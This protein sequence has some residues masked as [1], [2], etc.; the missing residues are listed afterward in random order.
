MITLT[1]DIP[2]ENIEKLLVQ[3]AKLNAKVL[4]TNLSMLDEL[5][6]DDYR[7]HFRYRAEVSRKKSP[8][9]QIA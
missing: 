2:D 9:K 6:E 8:P 1:L 4:E 5:T 3:L 7:K